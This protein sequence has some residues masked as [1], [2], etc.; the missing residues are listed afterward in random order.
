[1]VGL[2]LD[3]AQSQLDLWIAA[4]AAVASG[5]EYTI[6]SRHLRR[7]D[8]KE[9]T[10]KIDYWQSQL[11]KLSRGGSGGIRVRGITPV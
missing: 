11:Q 10:A 4:D 9:I 5:Q 3:T 8:A 1:M 6:G 2:T 7:A